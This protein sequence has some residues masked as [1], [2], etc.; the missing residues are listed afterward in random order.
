MV[1]GAN[2][3]NH[4]RD[5]IMSPLLITDV[6]LEPKGDL[7]Q[8][9][10]RS[11]GV[12]LNPWAL[13][14]LGVPREEGDALTRLIED[15]PAVEEARLQADRAAAILDVLYNN[16][17]G[18]LEDLDSQVLAS[19][20]G[21]PGIHNS[22]L[23][24][25]SN[26]STQITRKL[27]EDLD[28]LSN[29]PSML[30]SGPAAVMLGLVA[31]PIVSIPTPHPVVVPSTLVQDQ[32][33]ASA[34]E[35][36]F[37]VVTGPPGTGKSQVLVNVVAAAVAR[38]ESVLFASKNN[39][40]VD[41]VF[42]RLAL[43][44]AEPCIVR[45][46]ASSQRRDV[47]SSIQRM[48]ATP[49]KRVDPAAVRRQWLAVRAKVQQ[50]Y[51][52]LHRRAR[53]DGEI[54]KLEADLRDRLDKL[55]ANI[56]LD[57]DPH[58]LDKL[59]QEVRI[60]LDAFGKRLG[61]LRRWKKHRHRLEQAREKLLALGEL[62]GLDRDIVE[63]PLRS[64][65]DK[66][67]RSMVPRQD[68]SAI[69]R[70]VDTI[71]SLVNDSRALERSRRE[72][73]ALP[74]KQ[75]LDDQLHTIERQR[76]ESGRTFL[77]ARW[78]QIRRNDPKSRT[79]AGDLAELLEK[80]AGSGRG[81]RRALGLVRPALPA[82]P[83]WGVTNL[84]ARTNL[85]LIKGLFDLVVIDEAS[86]CDVAS[87][88]PLLARGRR[89]LIIG[90]QR[91][92]THI[93]SLSSARERNIGRRWALTDE[94]INEFSY[95]RRSCFG[96]AASR[97]SQSPI[98]LDLHFRSHPGIIGFSNEHFYDGRLELCWDNK[99]AGS[100][101]SWPAIE[102]KR[103][104]G[105]SRQGPRGRSRINPQEARALVDALS[106]DMAT[107]RELRL[108]VGIVTPY[109]SQVDLIRERLLEVLDE[110]WTREITV[111]TAHRF[112]GDE[113][114]IIYFGPSRFCGMGVAGVGWVHV[115]RSARVW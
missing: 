45:A 76:V 100:S 10:P 73:D 2:P 108:S 90:D 79:A 7:W 22:G 63:H 35:N 9:I 43:T 110:E 25:T 105:D 11:N 20:Q 106:R 83:V 80:V 78:E 41:V 38:N 81:A 24:F 70:T 103:V 115:M 15:T 96:L 91:Q 69:E 21:T 44:S 23:I 64:V 57:I 61:F 75:E 94:R 5:L 26:G 95:R 1:F 71:R 18:G 98:F 27:L 34:M 93:T 107:Y 84:S 99:G 56:N 68:F 58:Q 40:A 32:A 55:P 53:L 101:T 19:H 88:L 112:Q 30:S 29:S 85:P 82:I 6:D 17:I 28:E 4:G 3:D 67:K 74:T 8:I 16:G 72:L 86:Q 60:A 42:E 36:D 87:A 46:G 111:A 62:V 37:T 48:L 31:A 102:W 89:A 65:S 14:L 97:V 92:L 109:R 77:D 39:K 13:R 54:G 52:V 113:R 50:V 114:D 59:L 47:A 33:I 12:D 49:H 66:P 104:D 51:D